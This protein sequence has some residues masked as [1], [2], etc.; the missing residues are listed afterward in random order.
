[1]AETPMSEVQGHVYQAPDHCAWTD[2]MCPEPM[3]K[4]SMYCR[5]HKIM[6]RS[7][8]LRNVARRFFRMVADV[9]EDDELILDR[10]QAA[11]QLIELLSRS[12]NPE[13][14]VAAA[15]LGTREMEARAHPQRLIIGTAAED[16]PA[17]STG[18][19]NLGPRGVGCFSPAD[20]TGDG[21]PSTV[22]P[23]AEQVLGLKRKVIGWVWPVDTRPDSDW[24]CVSNLGAVSAV[25]Q[26]G[27]EGRRQP[28]DRAIGW[29]LQQAHD[30]NEEA[31]RG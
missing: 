17:G 26:F 1:M 20:E 19:V 16:I 28:R 21:R 2:P 8:I 7:D 22:P 15:K 30:L 18:T 23:Y 9:A 11:M 5:P 29:V 14:L 6:A 13:E 12:D 24:R 4:G 31:D 3:E 10:T 27:R 25:E